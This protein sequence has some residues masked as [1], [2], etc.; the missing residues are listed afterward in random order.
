VDFRNAG[1]TIKCTKDA[2]LVAVLFER[3]GVWTRKTPR[4]VGDGPAGMGKETM[5]QCGL[6]R[7]L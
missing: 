7:L 6:E 5:V 4:N 2:Y 3:G 1:R